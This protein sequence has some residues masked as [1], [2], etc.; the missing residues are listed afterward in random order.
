[1]LRRSARRIPLACTYR[2]TTIPPLPGPVA[3]GQQLA[4]PTTYACPPQPH[5]SRRLTPPHHNDGTSRDSMHPQAFGRRCCRARV[6][7]CSSSSAPL[8]CFSRFFRTAST[9][10]EGYWSASSGWHLEL[11]AV[12]WDKGGNRAALSREVNFRLL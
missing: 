1:M 12:E 10:Q 7:Y 9:A 8:S 2:P 6:A 5:S 11:C 4:P 3:H